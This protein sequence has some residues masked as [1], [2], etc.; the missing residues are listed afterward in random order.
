MAV[1]VLLTCS[2]SFAYSDGFNSSPLPFPCS[3]TPRSARHVEV[4]EREYREAMAELQPY[5]EAARARRA[6]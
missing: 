1:V 3:I 2:L 5:S 4:V 6:F